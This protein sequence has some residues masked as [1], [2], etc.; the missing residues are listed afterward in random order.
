M[1]KITITLAILMLIVPM[2]SITIETIDG[3]LIKGEFIKKQETR[4]TVKTITGNTVVFEE[5]IQ[6]VMSDTGNDITDSFLAIEPEKADEPLT[7]S[8]LQAK[9]QSM[10]AAKVIATPIWALVLVTLGSFIYAVAQ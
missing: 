7:Q 6:R 4:Y 8:Q 3:R 10:A 2:L 5:E 1:K 9:Q